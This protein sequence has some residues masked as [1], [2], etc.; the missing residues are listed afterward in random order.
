VVETVSVER[1]MS[2]LF[3]AVTQM[4]AERDWYRSLKQW[5]EADKIKR[6]IDQIRVGHEVVYKIALHDGHTEMWGWTVEKN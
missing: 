4:V 2:F 3:P 5:D 6:A 1:A